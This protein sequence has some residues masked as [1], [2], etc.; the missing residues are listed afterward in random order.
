MP[1]I[2]MKSY[3]SFSFLETLFVMA[4]GRKQVSWHETTRLYCNGLDGKFYI[5]ALDVTGLT[6][7]HS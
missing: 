1:P 2:I 7:I 5:L 6:A 3:L 4:V